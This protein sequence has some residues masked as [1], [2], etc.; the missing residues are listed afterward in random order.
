MAMG[1]LI[2]AAHAAVTPAVPK[3]RLIELTPQVLGTIVD[4]FKAAHEG[5]DAPAGTA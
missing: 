4:T 1:G 2:F 3:E 5:R